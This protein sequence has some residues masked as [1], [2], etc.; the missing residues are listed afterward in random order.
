MWIT[1]R[2]GFALT[3]LLIGTLASPTA[4]AQ[5]DAYGDAL[6]AGAVARLGTARFRHNITPQR[7]AFTPNGKIL[8]SVAQGSGVRLWEAH[9]GR[10]L[11]HLSGER[12][13]DS[14]AFSPDGAKVFTGMRLF[15]VAS[16]KELLRFKGKDDEIREAGHAAFSRDGRIIATGPHGGGKI[17]FWDAGTGMEIRRTEGRGQDSAIAALAFSPTDDVILAVADFDKTVAIWDA[18]TGKA[19]HR[20]KAHAKSARCVA[21]TPDGATVVSGSEDGLMRFWD[22]KSGQQLHEIKP[23]QTAVHSVAFTTDGKVL[24]AGG[25]G[26]AIT[27]WDPRTRKEIRR[28]HTHDAAAPTLAFSPGGKTLVSAAECAIRLWDPATGKEIDP[29]PAH[30]SAITVLRFAADG[31]SILSC[32]EDKQVIQWDLTSRRDSSRLLRGPLGPIGTETWYRMDI[33]PDGQTLAVASLDIVAERSKRFIPG[34]HLWNTATGT[35]VGT[36]LGHTERVFTFRFSPSGK[37]L[38]SAGLDAGIK[39]WDVAAHQEL[40]HVGGNIFHSGMAFAPDGRSIAGAGVDGQMRQWDVASGKEL[41]RWD[42]GTDEVFQF[43]FSSDGRLIA[44]TDFQV[45]TV[46][47]ADTGKQIIQ[48]NQSSRVRSLAFSPNG[49]VVAGV[50]FDRGR[51][52]MWDLRT[53][54]EIRL[55]TIPNTFLFQIAFSPDGQTLASAGSDAAVMLWDATGQGARPDGPRKPLTAKQLDAL[56]ADLHAEAAKSEPAI[57]ALALDA[58][59]ATPFLKERLRPAPPAD[60]RQTARLL[61]DLGSQNFNLRDQAER[62]LIEL[63][64]AAEPALR[65]FLQGDPALEVRRRA[66][67][68]LEKRA[69][70]ELQ[71]MRAIDALEQ[72]GS[73]EARAIL[74]KL[75]PETVNPRVRAGVE[76]ALKRLASNR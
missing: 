3:A 72:I 54:Q 6:P 40:H 43:V 71:Q 31:K 11:H 41:R 4:R 14:L 55:L 18:S 61:A 26:G 51:I 46:W 68:I 5:M 58:E 9:T 7:L 15:E 16:G 65:Q 13:S 32:G 35:K 12:F 24:A 1:K 47:A 70:D 29:V 64:A 76:T 28:W 25:S 42:T 73:P 39:L 69:P 37:V 44:G 63:G 48:F 36:L 49:R 34:I 60:A 19:L 2:P 57:W 22:V 21:F 52:Q 30:R 8:A 17:V 74:Q 38:A 62:T 67:R 23:G 56:W 45:V 33:A 53:G 50:G 59:R 75:V 27:L 20:I 10:L 66:E